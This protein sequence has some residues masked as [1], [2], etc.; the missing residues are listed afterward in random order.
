MGVGKTTYG[1]QLAQVLD[2]SFI[3]LDAYIE[4]KEGN[5]ISAIF[6]GQG[7][8]YFR[9]LEIKY[10]NQLVKKR[11]TLIS[12]GGGT[13]CN[14]KSLNLVKSKGILICLKQDWDILYS[15]LKTTKNR[16]LV[17]QLSESTLK[18]LYTKRGP[19]YSSA[20][21]EI[22]INTSFDGQK[23]AKMLRFINK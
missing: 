3:D 22:R 1:A 13:I 4:D 17:K 10:L 8:D 14:T 16:P 19:F 20:Q 2:Y 21:L 7:E 6:K 18:Q 5:T 11:N 12:L 15:F 23:V 9:G